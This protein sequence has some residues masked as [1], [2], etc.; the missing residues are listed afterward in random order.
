MNRVPK[1]ASMLLAGV[2]DQRN[3]MIMRDP[4]MDYDS[5]RTHKGRR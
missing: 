2:R 3:A 4:D 1:D 5:T